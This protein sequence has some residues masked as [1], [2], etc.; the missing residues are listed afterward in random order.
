MKERVWGS[1]LGLSVQR[2]AAHVNVTASQGQGPG[3]ALERPVRDLAGS[4]GSTLRQRFQSFWS[5]L[6]VS[7]QRGRLRKKV[8]DIANLRRN[9]RAEMVPIR[10]NGEHQESYGP[11]PVSAYNGIRRRFRREANPGLLSYR[12]GRWTRITRDPAGAAEGMSFE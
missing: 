10:L 11:D 3:S 8:E 2:A 5:D 7:A 4:L 12:A 9:G 6:G 1:R